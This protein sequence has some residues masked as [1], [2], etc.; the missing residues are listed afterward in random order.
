MHQY[1]FLFNLIFNYKKLL[2]KKRMISET[3]NE[4][5][6]TDNHTQNTSNQHEPQKPKPT[7][8]LQSSLIKR[9][10]HLF[11]LRDFTHTQ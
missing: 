5:N 8:A 10:N 1:F 6:M 2:I 9:T 11:P 3:S 4:T 7:S